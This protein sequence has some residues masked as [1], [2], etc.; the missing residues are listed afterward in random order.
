MKIKFFA[1]LAIAVLAT[2]AYAA[3][4]L[5]SPNPGLIIWTLASFSVLF[6]VLWKFGFPPLIEAVKK[7]EQALE[8]AIAAAARE[9]EEAA[10]LLAEQK[11]Q[12]DAARAEGDKFIAEARVAGEK[13]RSVMIEETRRQ[14][15]E[16]LDGARREIGNEKDRAIKEL[17]REAVDLA[18][19]GASKVIEKNLDNE[20]NRK[21]VESYLS[22]LAASG[23]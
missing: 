5:L 4:D 11:K 14:Q 16:M 17:R 12:L 15:Q 7:R 10:A 20:G 8:D 22:S 18:I 13:V 6:F 19:A 9:R 23:H 3:Q 21:L 2:P 1:L